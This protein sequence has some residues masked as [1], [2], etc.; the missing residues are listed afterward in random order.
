MIAS[1]SR[2]SRRT[3][4]KPPNTHLPTLAFWNTCHD[5]GELMFR[6]LVPCP[7]YDRGP[8]GASE[9]TQKKGE[10]R[11]NTKKLMAQLGSWCK[12][13]SCG[14]FLNICDISLNVKVCHSI[15]T[16]KVEE[17]VR[18]FTDIVQ[19]F[20]FSKEHTFISEVNPILLKGQSRDISV[21]EFF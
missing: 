17:K 12:V 14:A 3:S 2:V 16:K 13:D 11:S 6:V 8:H 5:T 18:T 10:A 15:E 21:A 20:K 19:D 1:R 7:R 9:Q 4:T